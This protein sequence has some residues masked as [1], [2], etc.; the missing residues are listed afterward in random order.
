MPEPRSRRKAGEARR[1]THEPPLPTIPARL[2]GSGPPGDGR[3]VRGEIGWPRSAGVALLLAGIL[4]WAPAAL[5]VEASLVPFRLA[6][7]PGIPAGPEAEREIVR[8]AQ[9]D[10]CIRSGALAGRWA[11]DLARGYGSPLFLFRAPGAYYVAE[12]FHLLGFA[13]ATSVKLA[14]L[15]G[16]L[17]SGLL[18]FLLGRDLW[19]RGAGYVLAALYTYAPA[20]L[21]SVYEQASLAGSIAFVWPPLILWGAW[22]YV[23]GRRAGHWLAGAAGLTGLVLTD[24]LAA[25]VLVPALGL[26][27]ATLAAAPRSAGCRGFLAL[28]LAAPAGATAFF[29]LPALAELPYVSWAP[30]A[31]VGAPAAGL[32]QR[33]GPVH[34]SLA[35]AALLALPLLWRRR[36]PA[37]YWIPLSLAIAALSPTVASLSGL[38]DDLAA[39]R[40]LLPSILAASLA[41]ASVCALAGER[42]SRWLGPGLAAAVVLLCFPE[43]PARRQPA[44]A[45]ATLD[46]AGVQAM[47]RPFD[48]IPLPRSVRL[49]PADAAGE[50][51]DAPGGCALDQVRLGTDRHFFDAVCQGKVELGDTPLRRAAKFLSLLTLIITAAARLL[52]RRSG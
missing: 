24:H 4:L 43:G 41:G 23:E 6:P 48:G 12:S 17:A 2:A 27:V 18:A 25:V 8:T 51:F 9:L 20:H 50:P 13:V 15:V 40:W 52:P 34:L 37:R 33:L 47:V 16:L 1:L 44:P 45:D 22:R 5:F 42:R 36:G 28:M 26:Y 39:W 3:R 35:A 11:P 21:A 10:R 31:A 38:R 32:V 7:A 49:P 46:R 30:P 29:W 19:G 14:H